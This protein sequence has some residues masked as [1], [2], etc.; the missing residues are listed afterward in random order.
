MSERCERTNEWTSEWL[1]T[2]RVSRRVILLTEAA[3]S[4]EEEEALPPPRAPT[5]EPKDKGRSCFNLA[6]KCSRLLRPSTSTPLLLLL[7]LPLPLPRSSLS[8]RPPAELGE[9]RRFKDMNRKDDN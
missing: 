3:A 2:Q 1:S 6:R 8:R 7:L 9:R 4:E 5:M